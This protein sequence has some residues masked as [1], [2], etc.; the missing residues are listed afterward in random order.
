[1]NPDLLKILSNSNKEIDNQKLMDYLSGQLSGKDIHEVEEGMSE[2][3]FMNDAIEGLQEVTNKQNIEVL[4]E[5]L[6]HDLHKKLGQKKS[7]KEKRKLKEYFWI[8][9]SIVIILVIITAAWFVIHHLH[10]AK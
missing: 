2:S 7:R 5:Q 3:E 8:Y 4:V 9:F 1:M 6:N 10:V